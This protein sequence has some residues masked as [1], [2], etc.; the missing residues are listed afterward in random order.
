M[1]GGLLGL[2]GDWG[3]PGGSQPDFWAA[4]DDGEDRGWLDSS[5][6][7]PRKKSCD[8]KDYIDNKACLREMSRKDWMGTSGANQANGRS[9]GSKALG[10]SPEVLMEIQQM[11]ENWFPMLQRVFNYYS[12][13]GAD[14]S[15]NINGMS[16]A[17]LV[18]MLGE[19]GLGLSP[20]DESGKQY[21]RHAKTLGEDG[22]D[23]LWI[24]V[25]ASTLS[26]SQS[27]YNSNERL[28]RAEFLEILVRAAIDDKDVAD[29]PRCVNEICED[30]VDFLTQKPHAGLVFHDSSSWR[31]QH[32]YLPETCA[33]LEHHD[34]TLRNIFKIYAGDIVQSAKAGSS[35]L[36]GPDEFFSLLQDLGIVKEIGVRRSYLVFVHS[37]MGVIDESTR[38]GQEV[39]TQLSYEGF[40]EAIVRVAVL[41]TLPNDREMKQRGF[42][43][44]GEYLGAMMDQGAFVY[45]AW[46]QKTQRAMRQRKVDSIWRRIDM[47]VLLLISIVQFGVEKLPGG[48]SLLL[49]GSPD[50]RLSYEEV[51]RFFKHPTP[52][53]F[54][55]QASLGSTSPGSPGGGATQ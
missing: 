24:S 45:N 8:A 7:K 10:A 4:D 35:K 34:E 18:I 43:F 37:R 40:L 51:K 31:K 17:G 15:N 12:H 54:D 1:D 33:V 19:S 5:I 16:H 9:F 52:H 23:L 46:V 11:L 53:V 50:E 47:F 2:L 29:M 49:R 14:V 27:S 20:D 41:K 13:V 36:M 6:W 38:K 44:P 32:L 25:N 21:A 28:T 39:Q 22:F 42:A 3:G 55:V 26:K 30:L 48:A